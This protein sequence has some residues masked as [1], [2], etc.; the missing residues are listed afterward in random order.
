MNTPQKY[1]IISLFTLVL[2]ILIFAIQKE[3]IILN[4]RSLAHQTTASSSAHK[5]KVHLFY[6]YNNEWRTDVTQIILSGHITSNI[7]QLISRW[8]ALIHEEKIIKKK[9]QIQAVLLNY[10]GQE[11]FISL[12]RLPWNKEASTF[13]KWMIIEGMLKTIKATEASLKKVRF[14]VNH[15]LPHDPHLDFTNP[16]PLNGFIK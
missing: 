13:E 15:Q 2:G 6:W 10:D 5:K 14:L 3:W 11:L 1:L 7:Q 12:D 16:W 4:F 9:V 8:L